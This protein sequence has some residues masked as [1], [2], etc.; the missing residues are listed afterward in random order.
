M[1]YLGICYEEGSG[2]PK[3]EQ[4]AEEWY[5]RAA[6]LGNEDAKAYFSGREK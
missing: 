4:I 1:D 5:R 3:D 2:V 6:A